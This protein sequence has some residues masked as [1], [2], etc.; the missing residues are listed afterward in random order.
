MS[1]A[2]NGVAWLDLN[3][4]GAILHHLFL[5]HIHLDARGNAAMADIVEPALSASLRTTATGPYR[6]PSR[7]GTAGP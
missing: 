4:R 2:K 3:D 5:E 6:S 7:A 1:P